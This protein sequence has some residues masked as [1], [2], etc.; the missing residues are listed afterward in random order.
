M[1]LPGRSPACCYGDPASPQARSDE[2]RSKVLVVLEDEPDMQLLIAMQLQRDPR[3][4]T[5]GQAATAAEALD[6]LDSVHPGLIIL[7][8]RIER[9]IMGLQAAPLLKV[10]APNALILLFT[11]F[12]MRREADD[13]PAV[14]AFLRKDE[15]VRL[16]PTVQRL[17]G[18]SDA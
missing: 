5:L 13:E 9:D 17:L 4:E 10:K 16:L 2:D 8:H 1:R 12:D 18:L 14:D 3:L 7:D 11:A 15:L 6:L